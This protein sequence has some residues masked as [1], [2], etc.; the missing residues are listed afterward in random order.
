MPVQIKLTD[1]RRERLVK[2]IRETQESILNGRQDRE[3]KWQE[4]IQRYEARTEPKSFPWKGASSLHVPMVRISVDSIKARIMNALFAQER[5]VTVE[6]LSEEPIPG[7]ENPRTG[8]PLTWRDVADMAE[9]YINYEISPAGAVDFHAFVDDLLDEVLLLGT[10]IPKATWE[11]RKIRRPLGNGSYVD[12]VVY[13]NVRFDVPPLEN[14]YFPPHYDTFDRIPYV[15]H[16]YLARPSE[17]L[18]RTDWNVDKVRDFL[19]AKV[20]VAEISPI[21]EA[22]DRS[23]G[24]GTQ[25]FYHDEEQWIAETWLRFDIDG[26][27]KEIPLVIDHAWDDPSY[28]FR[29]VEWPYEHGELPFTPIRYI[30]RRKRLYGMGVPESLESLDEGLSTAVN[31]MIDNVTVANTRV[32]S[33]KSDAD[34]MQALQTLWP[35]KRIPRDEVDDIVP[36]QAGEVYPSIFEVQNI[37]RD[38]SERTVKLSDYNLGR[39][40]TALGSQGTATSTLA[41]IQ[42]GNQYFDNIT[43][44]VRVGINHMLQQWMDLLAQQKPI[45]RVRHVLGDLGQPFLGALMLP[46]GDLRSRIAIRISFSSTA[47]TRELARQEEIA[48]WQVMYQYWQGMIQ[49]AQLRFVGPGVQSPALANL[50]DQ[51]ADGSSFYMKKLLEA[52]GESRTSIKLPSW[53]DVSN[54]EP[55]GSNPMALAQGLEGMEAGAG[56]PRTAGGRPVGGAPQVNPAGIPGQGSP[57]S[58]SGGGA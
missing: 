50:L 15:T 6:P 55:P 28:I 38:Y 43:R 47:A 42:E 31:Q 33:V 56:P 44:D 13:D 5:V 32:W 37:L 45:D 30:K 1:K 40:S 24:V 46:Q 25:T 36:M 52:F 19:S 34:A 14:I 16:T 2:A 10:A 49:L 7:T 29:V 11:M 35:N 23:E 18:Q 53:K 21:E 9:Q 8:E 58:G 12:N 51:I 39:E 57:D 41:L 27:G 17:L 20:G 3:R 26:S 48:K 54:A 22:Q 4:F